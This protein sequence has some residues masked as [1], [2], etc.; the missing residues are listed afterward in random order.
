MSILDRLDNFFSTVIG[1]F[2]FAGGCI[3]MAAVGLIFV[4]LGVMFVLAVAS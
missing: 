2:I 3:F 1:C 4:A